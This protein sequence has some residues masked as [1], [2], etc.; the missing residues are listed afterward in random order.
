MRKFLDGSRVKWE[1]SGDRFREGFII[2]WHDE[3]NG[4]GSGYEVFFPDDGISVGLFQ[5]D[6]LIQMAP[7][8]G[9]MFGKR[10]F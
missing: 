6:E 7:S 3:Y 9:D 5:D 4:Y 1:T 10:R 8:F 2:K